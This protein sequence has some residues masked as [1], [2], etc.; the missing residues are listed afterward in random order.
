MSVRVSR[1]DALAVVGAT[2]VGVLGANHPAYASPAV[3][4]GRLKQSVCRWCYGGIS[5]DQLCV[6]VKQMGLV[7]IDLLSENE[8]ATAA[9]YGLTCAMP[10]GPGN[11]SD[12]WNEP[13]NHDRLVK[14]SERLLPLVKAAGLPSMILLSGNRRGMSYA[15]GMTNCAAG[16]K[17]IVPLAEQL[18]VNLVLEL[19]N[20]KRDHKDY[21]CDHTA[22]GV[23]LCKRVGSDRLKLLYD[24]YH[25]QIMEGDVIATIQENIKYIGHFHTGGV[26]GRHEIDDSQE[27]NYR[28]IAQAIVDAGYQGYFAHEFI[29]VHDPLTSLRKAVELCDV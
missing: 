1:R 3:L 6:A 4:K 10:N 19:L 9:K 25:M 14:E 20:S 15:D 5:L 17:R 22:W 29:P 16:I 11:I 26:P 12:G 13:K 24:I 23:E 27:L 28:R 21:L 7:S 8:W 18:G 2:A